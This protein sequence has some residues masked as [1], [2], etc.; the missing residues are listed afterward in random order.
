[1]NEKKERRN[2][3]MRN[4]QGIRREYLI[5]LF[6]MKENSFECERSEDHYTR[7]NENIEKMK[8]TENWM[9]CIDF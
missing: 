7:C 9:G 4:R 6:L 5:N 8:T 2:G 3:K 1:M